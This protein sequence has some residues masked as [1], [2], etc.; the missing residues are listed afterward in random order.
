MRIAHISDLHGHHKHV[1]IPECDLLI[2]SG[3]LS[4]IGER[5]VVESFFAWVGKQVQC[6]FKVVTAGNHDLTLDPMRGGNNGSTPEWLRE[7]IQMAEKHNVF[8]LL[9]EL[10]NVMGIKIWASPVSSWFY[11]DRWAF[12]MKEDQ[13]MALYSQ[14]PIGTDIVITHGPSL[15][16]VDWCFNLPGPVGSKALDYHLKRV[17]PLLHFSGHIHEAYGY[18]EFL[19]I[20]Y[21]NGSVCDLNYWLNNKPH[22]LDV[23]F[24]TK[25]VNII[26]Y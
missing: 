7:V 1:K 20:H 12:N 8:Y 16:H 14:I 22:L 21:F 2:C 6:T 3:D 13:E 4:M 25:E 10:I 5:H 17:K 24:D 15:G 26:K 11:G 19:G 23:D 9:N 18:E